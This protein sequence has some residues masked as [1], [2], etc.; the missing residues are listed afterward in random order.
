MMS[1]L[2]IRLRFLLNKQYSSSHL[3]IFNPIIAPYAH[4]ET[5][6]PTEPLCPVFLLHHTITTTTTTTT[7]KTRKNIKTHH[8]H[9]YKE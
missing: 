1:R 3:N 7:A 8:I 9:T 5:K 4:N 6:L 2:R